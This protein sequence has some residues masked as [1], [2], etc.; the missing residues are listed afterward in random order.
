MTIINDYIKKNPEDFTEKQLDFGKNHVKS[1]ED[2]VIDNKYMLHHN[3]NKKSNE[4]II[5]LGLTRDNWIKTNSIKHEE[6]LSPKDYGL[7][8][9]DE[10]PW[11]NNNWIEKI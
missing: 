8:P 11:H 9:Y 2:L 10:G 1:V 4:E 5:F 3:R 7:E 6:P